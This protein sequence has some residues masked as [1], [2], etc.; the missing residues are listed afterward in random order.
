MACFQEVPEVLRHVQGRRV[1]LAGALG[2]GLEADPLQFPG[3]VIVDLA[4]RPGFLRGDPFQQFRLGLAAEGAAAHQQLIKDR[5]E[6]VDVAAAVHAMPFTPR[7]FGTHVVGRPDMARTTTTRIVVLE[8]QAE[9]DEVRLA[10]G[11]DQDVARLDV[12]VDQ[13]L[14]VGV[15][16][17]PGQCGHQ[18]GRR[19]VRQPGPFDPRRQ[20]SPINVLENDIAGAFVR[21]ADILYGNDVGVV[22]PGDRAGFG[23]I[24]TR[25]P[26]AGVTS[27]AWGTLM[28]TGRWSSSS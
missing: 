25:L 28:A 21:A 16:E 24:P 12:P 11:V 17:R 27:E 23:Q 10:F 2:Q 9:I 26:P 18:L 1:P 15:V 8:R 20:I 3:H 22:E 6:A 13:P 5:A 4:G 7:L 19:R 14:L